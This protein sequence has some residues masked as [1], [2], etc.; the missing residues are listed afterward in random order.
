MRVSGGGRT[1]RAYAWLS[2]ALFIVFIIVRES[3]EH[4][5]SLCLKV[6][7]L[8]T[9]SMACLFMFPPF[10][11]LAR[12]GDVEKGKPFHHTREVVSRSLYSVVRHPQY[13][14]YMLLVLG[15]ILIDQNWICL[16]IGMAIIASLYLQAKA[17]EQECIEKFGKEYLDYMRRVPRFNLLLGLV[18]VLRK[19]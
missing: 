1:P 15:F 2:F 17:E 7:G 6:L 5:H 18:N 13:L 11:L 8:V 9:L 10:Y 4:G 3:V 14:G 12:Y 16:G 19:T